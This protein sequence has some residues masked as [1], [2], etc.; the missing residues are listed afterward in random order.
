MKLRS[1]D[2]LSLRHRNYI[3]LAATA[4]IFS[5][6]DPGRRIAVSQPIPTPIERTCVA[7]TLTM[8]K[9]VRAV[10][11]SKPEGVWAEL[12]IPANL[13]SPRQDGLA[14][15][16]VEEHKNDKGDF[17]IVFRTGW[18]GTPGKP[19]FREFVEKAFV[20][21]RDRTIKRCGGVNSGEFW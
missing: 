19:A 8:E 10:D 9:N 12:V 21:L 3:V 15:F 6:C 14:G 13:E 17:E 16:F 7:E 2:E 5:S 11:N 1:K 20:E 4:L 18:L